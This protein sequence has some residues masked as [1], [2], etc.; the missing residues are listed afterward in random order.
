MCLAP[1]LQISQD[2]IMVSRAPIYCQT[3]VTCGLP[4]LTLDRSGEPYCAGH[5]DTFIAA[6]DV[7]VVLTEREMSALLVH[8][9]LVTDIG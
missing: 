4:A 1:R 2:A 6:A 5:A 7:V 9:E 8:R 3:C